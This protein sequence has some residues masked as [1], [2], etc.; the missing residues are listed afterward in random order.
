M[1][2]FLKQN[3]KDGT[4]TSWLIRKGHF[5]FQNWKLDN[6]EIIGGKYAKA[7]EITCELEYV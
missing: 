2:W 5:N 3:M 4:P 1:K 7:K 6:K